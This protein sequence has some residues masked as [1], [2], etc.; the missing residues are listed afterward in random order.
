MNCNISL[1]ETTF[2]KIIKKHS[3]PLFVVSK[4]LG[5]S[6]AY[7]SHLLAGHMTMSASA[8]EKLEEFCRKLESGDVKSESR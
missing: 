8:A 5:F 7:T 3:V 2:K 4:F 1:Q 6:Y